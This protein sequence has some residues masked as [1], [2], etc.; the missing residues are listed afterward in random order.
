MGMLLYT[1][2]FSLAHVVFL[3]TRY[4]S[5]VQGDLMVGFQSLMGGSM[6]G[7]ICLQAGDIIPDPILHISLNI[8]LS[9]L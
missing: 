5:I 1:V 8:A 2:V 4:G 6:L 3:F 9:K 7:Y